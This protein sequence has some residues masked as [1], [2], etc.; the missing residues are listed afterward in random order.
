MSVTQHSQSPRPLK[1]DHDSFEDLADL[2][3]PFSVPPFFDT[4]QSQE[5]CESPL[6][7]NQ[8]ELSQESLPTPPVSTATSKQDLSPARSRTG[9]LTDAGSA[10][11]S[12]RAGSPMPGTTSVAGMASPSAFAT[13]NGNAPP[14]P[15][16]PRLTFQEKELR[17]INKEIKDQERTVEKARKEQERQAQAEEKAIR[18]A[19]KE[20]ERK[21]KEAEKETKRKAQEAEKA[22]KEEKKRRREEEKQKAEDEKRKKERSQMKLGNFFNISATVARQRGTSVDGK[23]RSMSPAPN[24]SLLGASA[25]SPAASTPSKPQISTYNKLFPAFFIQNNVTLAPIN[26]F[27]RDEEA[28]ESIQHIID[29]YIFGNRSPGKQRPFDAS[30]LF[31][32]AGQ[33]DIL[34]GKRCMPVREIMAEVN[35]NSSRPIDLTTDSQNS[36]IK[37]TGDLLR[38]IPMKFLKFQEDVRPPYRGT[39]TSRPISGMT[40]LARNPLK[41]DLPNTD[42]DYDSEAEWIEDEDAEDLNSE[43]EEDDEGVEDGEDMEGFLDDEG[44]ETANSKRLVLQGDL[45]PISTGLCWEDRKKRN[46]NVKMLPYRMEIIIGKLPSFCPR[47]P[48]R[49]LLENNRLIDKVH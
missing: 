20:T 45:E 31:H 40:K 4:Q 36:Q 47:L 13:L 5:R 7:E 44:D 14:P 41:R 15:K 39:Y 10:T 1:R 2:E 38:K 18:D 29:S 42:Y 26:R 21:K 33:N 49:Y 35:G 6:R 11:P 3:Q 19:E 27:E 43:G 17:R 37:R 32:L 30:S 8:Q 23:E 48:R 46:T 22:E 28:T 9:S 25:A 24:S 12:C 34:R 16:K